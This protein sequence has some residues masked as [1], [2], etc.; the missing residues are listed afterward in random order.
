MV[1]TKF[2]YFMETNKYIE[3]ELYYYGFQYRGRYL[4]ND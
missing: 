2:G 1:S 4:Q 3:T